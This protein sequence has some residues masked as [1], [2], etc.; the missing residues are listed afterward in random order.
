MAETTTAHYALPVY[1]CIKSLSLTSMAKHTEKAVQLPSFINTI[2]FHFIDVSLVL[3][4]RND[5][6]KWISH[7]I[8]L[9]KRETGFLSFNFCSDKY[10]LKMNREYLNHN[11]YTDIITFDLTENKIISGDIYISTDRVKENALEYQTS[12]K[13]ELHRV[14][15][16]GVLHL[17]GYKD[18]TKK[19]AA[20]MRKM[21][22]KYLSLRWF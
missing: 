10:L 5:L 8:D 22:A 20:T 4:N 6:R 17:C 18:K 3:R 11:Y 16:H 1:I 7:C 19:D 9:E 2:S 12:V 13:D 14:M 15:I 21:E